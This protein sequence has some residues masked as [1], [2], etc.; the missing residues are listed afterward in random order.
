[1][2]KISHKLLR[3]LISGVGVN[4]K[5]IELHGE[6]KAC[7][8]MWTSNELGL[9]QIWVMEMDGRLVKVPLILHRD[10]VNI[11]FTAKY[12]S[13]LYPNALFYLT[14]QVNQ[15]EM[16]HGRVLAE[17]W[18]LYKACNWRMKYAMLDEDDLDR[19]Y[20]WLNNNN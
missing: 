8:E 20:K 7:Y 1:M 9:V 12:I 4:P 2:G 13:F 3:Q 18:R 6:M 17:K 19:W 16:P 5:D 14:R 10:G 15:V 11:G